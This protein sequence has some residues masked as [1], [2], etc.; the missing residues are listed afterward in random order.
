[1]N[2]SGPIGSRPEPGICEKGPVLIP[3]HGEIPKGRR[4]LRPPTTWGAA[5]LCSLGFF[6]VA[7]QRGPKAR[8]QPSPRHEPNNRPGFRRI[9]NEEVQGLSAPEDTTTVRQ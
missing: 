8:L 9:A 7:P 5:I 6:K 1:M 4:L 3:L 2:L